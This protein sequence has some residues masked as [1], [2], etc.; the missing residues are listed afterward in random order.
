MKTT[1]AAF[2]LAVLAASQMQAFAATRT[3]VLT[4]TATVPDTCSA[5][6]NNGTQSRNAS[7]VSVSC[8]SASAYSI[9]VTNKPTNGALAPAAALFPAQVSY[10]TL[11]NSTQAVDSGATGASADVVIVSIAY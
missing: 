7:A 10:S 9:N 1:L 11:S 5:T 3:A 2:A 8:N 4:V 6:S